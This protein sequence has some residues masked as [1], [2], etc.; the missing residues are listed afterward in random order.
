MTIAPELPGADALIDLLHEHGVVAAVGHTDSDAATTARVMAMP[1]NGLATHLF[2]GMPPLHHRLPGPV[3]GALTAAARTGARV[4][5]IADGVHLADETVAMLFALLG[6][7]RVVLVT[8]AMAA[9]GMPDGEY[10][11][12]PQDV[13]V[14]EGVARLRG[15]GADMSIAGGTS[16]LV[17]V[18]RRVVQ[19]TGVGLAD[20]VL[21]ASTVPASVLGLGSEIGSLRAGGRADVLVVDDELRPLR[22]MRAGRWVG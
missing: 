4:E 20:A 11:L 10:R 12:G 21:S 5:V 8:D 2:N 19:R 6:P 14:V 1:G 15:D 13:S 17:D 18:V 3:A 7:D 16:R 22:V 9:A